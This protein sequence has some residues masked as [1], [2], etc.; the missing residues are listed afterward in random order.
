MEHISNNTGIPEKIETR[1]KTLEMQ[2]NANIHLSAKESVL[3]TIYSI[4]KF[5]SVLNEED[6][7]YIQCAQDAV[8]S[9]RKWGE[10]ISLPE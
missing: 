8:E 4:T 9:R 10:H 7:D 2:L 3:A 6:R 1:M 5:W